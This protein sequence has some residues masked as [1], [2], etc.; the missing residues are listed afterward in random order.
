MKGRGMK[1]YRM[2]S[3]SSFALIVVLVA[4]MSILLWQHRMIK[5]LNDRLTVTVSMPEEKSSEET[6]SSTL[7][8]KIIPQA[9]VWRPI[10]EKVKDTVVQVISQIA[11]VDLLQPFRSPSLHTSYGSAFFINED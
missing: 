2:V 1:T 5:N 10:Q 4:I 11:R 9:E 8:E 6:L 3:M 7:V